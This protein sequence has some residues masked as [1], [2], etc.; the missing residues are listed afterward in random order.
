MSTKL[1]LL[2]AA[3]VLTATMGVALAQG[4]GQGPSRQ[5]QVLPAP[6]AAAPPAEPAA[7]Y[8]AQNAPDAPPIAANAPPQNAAPQDDQPPAGNRIRR[9]QQQAAP[10]P[11]PDQ[12]PPPPP[13]TLRYRLP[14]AV[15]RKSRRRKA[16]RRPAGRSA[17]AQAQAALLSSRIRLS[18]AIRTARLWHGWRLRRWLWRRLRW[19]VWRRRPLLNHSDASS[20]NNDGAASCQRGAVCLLAHE[21]RAFRDVAARTPRHD[22]HR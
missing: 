4:Q 8:R 18:P 12:P 11:A 2:T 20:E 19:R 10:D 17:E 1:K 15:P 9:R 21:L 6:G 14:A 16:L 5:I 22:R 3:A 7:G 13:Q